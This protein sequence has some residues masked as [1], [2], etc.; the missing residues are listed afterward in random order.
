MCRS[1]SQ[2]PPD[3]RRCPSSQ[4]TTRGSA[5]S[6]ARSTSSKPA[7][8]RPTD[9]TPV[10]NTTPATSPAPSLDQS[11]VRELIGSAFGEL[12]RFPEQGLWVGDVRA[13]IDR[14]AG[15]RVP[16]EDVDEVVR[17]MVFSGDAYLSTQPDDDGFAI[18]DR[19][20][21]AGVPMGLGT[22]HKLTFAGTL[23][24]PT[25]STDEAERAH[26]LLVNAVSNVGASAGKVPLRE[27]RREV[28]RLAGDKR[29]SRHAVDV[30]LHRMAAGADVQLTDEARQWLLTEEDRDAVLSVGGG[31]RYYIQIVE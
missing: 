7:G 12:A 18:P 28:A 24:P 9:P 4:R 6:R 27:V 21:D 22:Y 11:A 13:E 10:P 17:Q 30:A 15:R 31:R 23:R 8:R 16:R 1:K 25:V 19:E 3:G 2:A 26:A 14:Q 5:T 29:L 20:R